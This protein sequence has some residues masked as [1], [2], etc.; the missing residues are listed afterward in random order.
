MSFVLIEDSTSIGIKGPNATAWLEQLGVILPTQANTWSAQQASMVIR[1]GR[2]EFMMTGPLALQLQKALESK[3]LGVYGVARADASYL[4][5]GNEAYALMAQVCAL[6]I[7]QMTE[8]Q[9]LMTQLAGVSVIL[10]KTVEGYRFW[11]DVSYQDYMS[12]TLNKICQH[13]ALVE[14][15]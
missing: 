1:L 12:Q 15:D 2:S 14:T 11:C 5:I 8:E 13:T 3:S 7:A 6:N 9:V 4:V 10:I